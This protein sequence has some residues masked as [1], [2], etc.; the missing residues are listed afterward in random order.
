YLLRIILNNLHK[1]YSQY[2][3]IGRWIKF[4]QDYLR[5]IY[6]KRRTRP[7]RLLQ[8]VDEKPPANRYA[9]LRITKLTGRDSRGIS[10]E[11]LPC[12]RVCR[13]ATVPIESLQLTLQRIAEIRSRFEPVASPI[14]D[15]KE[16][17]PFDSILNQLIGQDTPLAPTPAALEP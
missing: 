10:S 6:A 1:N 4:W 8:S 17:E 16:I 2:K 3:W 5:A 11:V 14:V 15:S 12:E 13:N 9:K 7:S